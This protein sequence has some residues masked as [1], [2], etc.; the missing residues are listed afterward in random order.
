[1]DDKPLNEMDAWDL[2]IL[3]MLRYGM[4]EGEAYGFVNAVLDKGMN[5]EEALEDV[6]KSNERIRKWA[7][8]AFNE[9]GTWK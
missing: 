3:A 6:K 5:L 1:M 2:T 7:P 9:D 8:S 4:N